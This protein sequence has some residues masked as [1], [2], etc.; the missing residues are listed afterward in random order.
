MADQSEASSAISS[1]RSQLAECYI[2]AR[3]AEAVGANITG[4]TWTLNDAGSLLSSAEYALSKGDFVGAEDFA[5]QSQSKL[6]DFVSNA[7]ALYIAA[8]VGPQR[9][10]EILVDTLSIC[11]TVAVLVGSF[12]LWSF[13]KKKYENDGVQAIGYTAA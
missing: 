10:Q 9:N 8:R 6:A 11:G 13:L 1:A 4:L 3:E 5:I 12:G 2:A 7:N